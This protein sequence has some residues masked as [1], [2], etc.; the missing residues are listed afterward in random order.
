MVSGLDFVVSVVFFAAYFRLRNY[1]DKTND[2]VDLQTTTTSDF[3]VEIYKGL[4]PDTTEDEVLEHFSSLYCLDKV[5][6]RGRPAIS[7]KEKK[8]NQSIRKALS[9]LSWMLSMSMETLSM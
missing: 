2:L 1:V 3:S 9:N 5:D 6:I 4:P 8:P 7:K